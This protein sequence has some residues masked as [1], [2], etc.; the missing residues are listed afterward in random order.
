MAFGLFKDWFTQYLFLATIALAI[1]ILNQ[2]YSTNF[3]VYLSATL[4]PLGLLWLALSIDLIRQ[5][6]VIP[7]LPFMIFAAALVDKSYGIRKTRYDV[8]CL[9]QHMIIKNVLNYIITLPLLSIP[10]IFSPLISVLTIIQNRS[11]D[12]WYIT[13]YMYQSILIAWN[14]IVNTIVLC[15]LPF[16][17]NSL[18][19]LFLVISISVTMLYVFIMIFAYFKHK[20]KKQFSIIFITDILQKF[21][22]IFIAFLFE[23]DNYYFVGTLT[24]FALII[25]APGYKPYLLCAHLNWRNNSKLFKFMVQATNDYLDRMYSIL[26]E[27]QHSYIES[28]SED[29][30]R[31]SRADDTQLMLDDK[32]HERGTDK[33]YKLQYEYMVMSDSEKKL[34][35]HELNLNVSHRKTT[36]TV[37]LKGLH[38]IISFLVS[39]IPFLWM[40][41]RAIIYK[42]KRIDFASYSVILAFVLVSLYMML[43][44]NF[45]REIYMDFSVQKWKSIINLHG[46]SLREQRIC[47]VERSFERMQVIAELFNYFPVDIAVIIDSYLQLL[48]CISFPDIDA[49]YWSD[50]N[51]LS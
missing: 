6:K 17:Y 23:Y 9:S 22:I 45:M 46:V 4:F 33:C 18:L 19:S 7:T 35:L 16:H 32:R 14:L 51:E 41:Y 12:I 27:L 40:I 26:H 43:M 34:C 20:K 42:T 21:S 10:I 25:D 50:D 48:E 8:W 13:P 11:E 39:L 28:D 38:L 31:V 29:D 36:L 24:V 30:S 2:L 37:I 1:L 5:D 15:I 44:V 47:Y 3:Y 49:I